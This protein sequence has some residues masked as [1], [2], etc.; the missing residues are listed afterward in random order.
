MLHNLPLFTYLMKI[1]LSVYT[2]LI[3]IISGCGYENPSN[4]LTVRGLEDV[5]TVVRDSSGVNHI[6]AANEHDLFFAQGYCAA[7]DRLFQFEMW[8]RQATG[9]VAEI[10][11]PGEVNRDIGARLFSFRGDLDAEFNHYHPRGK[12]IITSFTAG[13]N[14][15]V[16]QA[17]A[18]T[19]LLPIE[20]KLLGI[21]PG[22]W[23]PRDVISRHQGLLSNL[24]D[25]LRYGRAVAKIGASKLKQ[26]I[27]FEPGD[28]DLSIDPSIDQTG[29]FDSIVMPYTS[30][31]AA[32]KFKPEHL[33]AAYRNEA[34]AEQLA[35]AEDD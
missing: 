22:R 35:R 32:L 25:E 8:R 15:Y 9:T 17:L 27:P 12:Q 4:H 33:Q 7:R 2:A 14:A 28:P 20:F 23:N 3:L 31:R 29:L 10:L 34:N 11:G 1:G 16:D 24:P 13:V 21:R 26:L 30:F 5:V 6:Y 19:A 18:D